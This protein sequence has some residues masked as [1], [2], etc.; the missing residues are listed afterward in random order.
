MHAKF[1]GVR[2]LQCEPKGKTSFRA[3]ARLMA[4]P[5]SETF[6]LNFILIIVFWRLNSFDLK[7]FE[8][9]YTDDRINKFIWFG[10]ILTIFQLQFKV[11]HGI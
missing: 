7:L 4:R 1:I 6:T 5:D 2:Y 8:C 3:I 10:Q 9:N 11:F